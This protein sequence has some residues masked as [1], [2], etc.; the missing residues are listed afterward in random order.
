MVQNGIVGSI[1]QQHSGTGDNVQQKVIVHIQSLVP[2]NLGGAIAMVFSSIRTKDIA[3]AK[4]QLGMLRL[5][6]HGNA[7]VSALL[8]VVGIY[9]ELIEPE[10]SQT[11]FNTV[12]RIAAST[13]DEIVKDLC[14]AALLKLTRKT[15]HEEAALAYYHDTPAPGPYSREAFY[16][17]FASEEVLTAASKQLALTEGELTGIVDGAIRLQAIDIAAPAAVRLSELYPSYNARVL[18]L[19]TKAFR[20]NPA[21]KQCQYWLADPALKASVDELV[22][23]VSVLLELSGGCDV[24]LYDM[25]CPILNYFQVALPKRLL[26]VCARYVEHMEKGWPDVAARVRST[27]GDNSGL[28]EQMRSLT[29]AQ[30]SREARKA[31]CQARLESESVELLDAVFFTRLAREAELERWLALTKPINGGEEIDT[32]IIRLLARAQLIV[33]SKDFSERYKLGLEVDEFILKFGSQ[34]DELSVCIVVELADVLFDA[35]LPHKALAL[36]SQMLPEGQLWPSPFVLLHLKCLLETEQYQSFDELLARIPEA[37]QSLS[38]LNYRSMKEEALGNPEGALVLVDQMVK[39]APRRLFTW[40]RGFE[41]RER[42]RE[43]EEQR[44]FHNLL[45]DDLLESFSHEAVLALRYITTAGN[46]KRA[47]PRL[48]RWFMEDPSAR[49]VMLVNFHF[50]HALNRQ[51]EFE[52]SSILPGYLEGVEFEQNGQPQTRLIIEEGVATGQYVLTRDSQLASLLVSLEVGQSAQINMVNYTLKGRLPPYVACIRLAA[53]LRHLQNDGSD[54]FAL[55]EVPDDPAQLVQFLEARL[56]S[57]RPAIQSNQVETIPLFIQGH[58]LQSDDAIKA[59]LQ[60]WSDSRIPKT[61]FLDEGVSQPSEVV[62]DAYSATYLAMTNLVDRLLDAGLTFVLPAETK[63]LV[64]RWVAN[65][66]R[67]DFLMM[68]INDAGQ[69]VRTTAADVQAREGH[70]VRGLQRILDQAVVLHPV[71]HDTSLELYSIKDGIDITVYLAMQLSSANDVP[72][73]CMD[74]AFAALHHSNGSKIA[75]VNHVI[76]SAI[77]APEFDFE[78]DR[79]GLALYAIGAL[80]RPLM[81]VELLGLAQNP[82][83]LSSFILY[84]IFQN[85]GQQ[86]FVEPERYGL[87]LNIMITHIVSTFYRADDEFVLSP[88][89]TPWNRYDEHVFNYGMRLFIA[90]RSEHSADFWTALAL[91]ICIRVIGLDMKLARHALDLFSLFANGHFMDIDAI[92]DYAKSI[93]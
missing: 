9:G 25:A 3:A 22:E 75:N 12:S 39:E 36:T 58:A 78:R 2:A 15:E 85:H 13:Q 71:M 47:E 68:G 65:V 19:I 46:F 50:G 51:A 8:E 11:A 60:A 4:L 73:L 77:E 79:H 87:L 30:D 72:W 53:Q 41:L 80:P 55:F 43:L 67:S 82:N 31:W 93:D 76:V 48:V 14:I 17:H 34:F 26:E 64:Q 57:N 74:T 61:L 66:T 59:A 35:D 54:V 44:R 33:C 92:A 42:Y 7:E 84:K 23:E 88:D 1:N 5:T 91:K 38:L 28:S 32:S 29:V 69:L 16:K 45:S 21:V 56:N 83:P 10:Q 40:L 89:Y 63:E 81:H 49:A 37:D 20:L 24:R 86:I 70:T 90:N 6:S 62:L 27:Q 52:V 18:L